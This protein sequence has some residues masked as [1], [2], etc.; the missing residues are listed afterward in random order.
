I[1]ATP[2]STQRFALGRNRLR[3]RQLVHLSYMSHFYFTLFLLLYIWDTTFYYAHVKHVKYFCPFGWSS[4][5]C[6]LATHK[7]GQLL[8]LCFANKVVLFFQTEEYKNVSVAYV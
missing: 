1:F 2:I 8:C 3:L 6:L 7:G 5:L 4:M